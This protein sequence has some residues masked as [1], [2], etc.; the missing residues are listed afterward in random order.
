LKYKYKPIN[1]NPESNH[2]QHTANDVAK[3][4]DVVNVRKRASD[5]DVALAGNGEYGA[6]ITRSQAIL[7]IRHRQVSPSLSY[8]TAHWQR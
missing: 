1:E 5:K 4:G 2:E 6:L 7:E 8:A 3:M